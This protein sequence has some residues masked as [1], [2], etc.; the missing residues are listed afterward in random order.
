MARKH[1][2][3]NAKNKFFTCMYF[4]NITYFAKGYHKINFTKS[5]LY[6]FVIQTRNL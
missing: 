5:T 2:N 4:L 6:F 3:H 1:L